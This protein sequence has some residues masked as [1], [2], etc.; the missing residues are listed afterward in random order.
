MLLLS[1]HLSVSPP[2]SR[3]QGDGRFYG[4]VTNHHKLTHLKQ[5]KFIILKNSE[6]QR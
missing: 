2:H 3:L 5:N 1:L 6:V 4:S